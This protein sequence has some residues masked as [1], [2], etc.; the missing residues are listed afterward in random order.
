MLGDTASFDD[1]NDDSLLRSSAS[2]Q[3]GSFSTSQDVAAFTDLTLGSEAVG[4]GLL[5]ADLTQAWI[6][7]RTA[8]EILPYKHHLV[9]GLIERLDEKVGHAYILAKRSCL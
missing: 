2:L 5:M 6:D 7:E 9:E 4:G 8:P 3:T 1:T